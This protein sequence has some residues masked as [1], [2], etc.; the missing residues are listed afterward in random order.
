MSGHH[1]INRESD[2]QPGEVRA[3]AAVVGLVPDQGYK[4][5]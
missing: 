2:I 4:S 3:T 1:A 5:G